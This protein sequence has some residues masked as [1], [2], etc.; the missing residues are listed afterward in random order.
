MTDYRAKYERLYSTGHARDHGR[1]TIVPENVERVSVHEPCF[2]CGI[3][4]GLCKH[5]IAA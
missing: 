2:R 5:R 1:P 4:R 3:A